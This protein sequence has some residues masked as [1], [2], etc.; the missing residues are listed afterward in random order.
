ML[1][2]AAYRALAERVRADP[3]PFMA[4]SLLITTKQQMG[5][6][7]VTKLVLNKPQLKVADAVM[8]MRAAGEAP[9]VIVLKARQPGVS[10]FCCGLNITT[11][12]FQPYATTITIAHLDDA[13]ERLF[14]K[15][16]FMVDHLPPGLRPKTKTDRKNELAFDYL[17]CKDGKAPIGSTGVTGAAGGKQIW[18]GM[19]IHGCHLSEL[20][21]AERAEDVL[22]GVLQA[23]PEAPETYVLIESTANG[24]GNT[25]QLEYSRAEAGESGFRPVFIAWWELPDAI[26]PPPPDFKLESDERDLKR[27]F[28]LTDEQIQWRRHTLYTRCQ[29]NIDLF[30]Q[31]YPSSASEA[32]L[33][34]GRPAFPTAVLRQM[35]AKALEQGTPRTGLLNITVENPRE[36]FRPRPGAPLTIYKWPHAEHT[37]II[38]ADPSA[39]VEGG[40]YSCAA[41]LD[42]QTQE[43]VAVWHGML[44]PIEFTHALMD[45]GQ[46]YNFAM[47]APEITGGCLDGTSVVRTL[48]W[49][50]VGGRSIESLVGSTP[51]LFGHH[52]GRI[53]PVRASAVSV[54]RAD[55][56]CVKL[57]YGLLGPDGWEVASLVLTPD[58]PV[59]V[60]GIPNTYV[61]VCELGVGEPLVLGDPRWRDAVVISVAP[62]SPRDVYCATVPVVEN[63]VVNGIVV[64]NHGFSVVEEGRARGYPN[65][66]VWQRTDRI[67]NTPTNYI[68][69]MTTQNTRPLL[70]D[71]MHYALVHGDIMI[72]DPE[73]VF[74]AMGCRY[75]GDN[76]AEG[77]EHDDRVFASMIAWRVH[78]E[79]P[80]PDGQLPRT[81]R[82][83]VTA[84]EVDPTAHLSNLD[85]ANWKD[86]DKE[87]ERRTHAP[88]AQASEWVVTEAELNAPP[89]EASDWEPPGGYW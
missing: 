3:R 78:L 16:K 55:A 14:R 76:R 34:T 63:F 79:M 32:F 30:L 57:E 20:G 39:G 4:T 27:A 87:L 2:I 60:E 51:I 74:E 82:T 58:H 44:T 29:G 35:H 61:P 24:M 65:W 77:D 70:F 49:G 68:G 26:M 40:D 7:P 72:W 19:T 56:P 86:V 37:Y 6:A 59:M 64:H 45:L 41:V 18:R 73:P 84:E 28:G 47:L 33:V 80:M 62:E 12:L 75:I 25:F 69:W 83:V 48:G 10:T 52:G 22:L 85:S 54:R 43:I 38:G 13:A 11:K 1:T 21:F 81:A 66:Y 5:Q 23:V 71:S 31:E 88:L 46:F 89:E 42:R 36:Q 15:E 67:K 8:Q 9:R 53:I 17:Q 50:S